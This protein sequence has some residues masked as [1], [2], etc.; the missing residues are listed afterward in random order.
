MRRS[1]PLLTMFALGTLSIDAM[2]QKKPDFTGT[3]TAPPAGV[4]AGRETTGSLGSGWG[5]SFTLRQTEDTLILERVFFAK[6][7]LQPA[8]RF[9]F[10]LDG[11]ETRN[12]VLMGRGEQ[13]QVSTVAWDG[14]KLVVTTV[15]HVLDSKEGQKIKSEVT[16]TLSLQRPPF[17]RSAWPP[18]LVVETV[19]SGALG[20]PPSTRRTVYDR[21]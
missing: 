2:A 15:Y 7:D 18:S 12:T 4:A 16:Q 3:W 6:A 5:P 13:V 8:M 9:R 17:G 1:F 19:R 10:A 11:S 14:D 20:G 21:N